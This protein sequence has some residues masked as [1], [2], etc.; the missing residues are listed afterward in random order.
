MDPLKKQ[1]TQYAAALA[2]VLV[3]S[4][5]WVIALQVNDGI[6]PIF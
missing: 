6:A 1:I 5:A 3:L 4:S 2:I